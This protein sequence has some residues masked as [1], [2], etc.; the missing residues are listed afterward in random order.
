[1]EDLIERGGDQGEVGLLDVIILFDFA[2]LFLEGEGLLTAFFLGLD[3]DEEVVIELIDFLIE[4]VDR[5][6]GLRE[7]LFEELVVA[8]GDEVF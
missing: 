1:M 2:E 6:P 7:F 8:V 4:G 5:L 3:D